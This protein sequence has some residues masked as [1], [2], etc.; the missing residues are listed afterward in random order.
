MPRTQREV[1]KKLGISRSYVSRLEKKALSAAQSAA[2]EL[3]K[4]RHQAAERLEEQI[5]TELCSVLPLEA[6]ARKY[7]E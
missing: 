2:E 5:L 4:A 6:Y 3:S 7:R 1:A